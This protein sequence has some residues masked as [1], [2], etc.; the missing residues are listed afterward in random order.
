MKNKS[1]IEG[2]SKQMKYQR[3]KESI[4]VAI[5]S[6]IFDFSHFKIGKTGQTLEDRFSKSTYKEDY[7]GI[8]PVHV[9][10]DPDEISQLEADLI[11]NFKDN[12]KCDN[13]RTTDKDEMTESDKY[14][15]YVVWN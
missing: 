15:L 3:L 12:P 14:T 5:A 11:E 2:V 7:K 4:R 10:D 1:I 13:N 9:S 8:I 6:S